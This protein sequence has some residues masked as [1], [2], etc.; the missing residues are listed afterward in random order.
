MRRSAAES[1]KGQTEALVAAAS[2]AADWFRRPAASA[3][4]AARTARL[5]ALGWRDAA[6]PADADL[7]FALR[8]AVEH[9]AQ[10]VAEAA[11]WG[12]ESDLGLYRT[13]EAVREA[14]KKLS[15]AA[16]SK[17]RARAAALVEAKKWAGEAERLRRLTR[18]AAHEDPSLAGA[19][20]R[21][22]VSTRLSNAAEAVQQA[23]DALGGTLAE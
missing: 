17:G 12:V 9:S 20:K 23:C 1:L 18:S 15:A 4:S 14:A 5:R 22:T 7:S 10:A 21:E 6:K 13:A 3:L 19:L 11:R 2:A 8:E 16:G